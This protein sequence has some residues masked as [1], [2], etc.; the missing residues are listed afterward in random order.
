MTNLTLEEL[1]K[2]A[3]IQIERA[4]EFYSAGEYQ[5]AKSHA[6]QALEYFPFHTDGLVCLGYCCLMLEEYPEAEDA[7]MRAAGLAPDDNETAIL[8]G[9]IAYHLNRFTEAETLL[10][11][12]CEKDPM[13]P[14]AARHYVWCLSL[15]E[16]DK[17][18]SCA[19][20]LDSLQESPGDYHLL[21]LFAIEVR[22]EGDLENA[23]HYA[24]IGESLARQ[25]N[26]RKAVR[27]FRDFRS[28][29]DGLMSP[30]FQI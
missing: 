9:I 14:E 22:N 17:K 28:Y 16:K 27:K 21:Y 4:I 3:A 2:S 24:Q 11:Q 6:Q 8:R 1:K 12:A 5:I 10:K 15:L 29:N 20:L 18:N 26:D 19:Y 23:L 13:H 25:A 7:A 30:A